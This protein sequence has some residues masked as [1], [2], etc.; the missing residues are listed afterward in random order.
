MVSWIL[1][2]PLVVINEVRQG[3]WRDLNFSNLIISSVVQ[4]LS[5]IASYNVMVDL[6]NDL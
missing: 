3:T 6:M 2:L 1:L 4:Y 5:S